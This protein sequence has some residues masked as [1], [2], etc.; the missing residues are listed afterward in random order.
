MAD[1]RRDRR[2]AGAGAAGRGRTSAPPI[3]ALPLPAAPAVSTGVREIT[4]GAGGVTLSALLAEPERTPPRGTIVA[5]HGTGMSAGYFDGQA[6]PELSLLALAASLG[7][8]AL[9]VDR[10]G[11]GR[12]TAQLPHGQT[13]G[14]QAATLRTALRDFTS[15]FETGAGVFLLAHSF[16]GKVA[17]TLAADDLG[18]EL[19]GVDISGC[20]HQYAVEADEPVQEASRASRNWG[21]LRLYPPGTFRSSASVVSPV[22]TREAEDARRWSE[23][24]NE[25]AGRIRVP[26]RFTFAEYEY[27]WR[28]DPSALD[29][30]RARLAV[31][32]RVVI[33]R[34][35]GAGHNISLGWAARTYHLRVFGF[36]EE[37]IL[38]TAVAV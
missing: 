34:Q 19:L 32:P 4:L 1:E 15:R 8:T 7:Y 16:G 30:I 28:H 27:W 20:G 6:H 2:S 24:F 33:D 29:D 3:P 25:L 5:L 31:A 10:P 12:S 14:E 13:V 26:V 37:C 18:A 21:P 35:H 38:R 23:A 22:P 11:Y 9:A 36:L 17:L